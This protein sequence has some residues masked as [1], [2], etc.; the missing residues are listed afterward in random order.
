MSKSAI[1]F[2][3]WISI[4]DNSWP[5][6]VFRKHTQ[7]LNALMWANEPATKYV[8]KKLKE[9]GA[10]MDDK[11]SLHFNFAVQDGREV[12]DDLED[13]SNSFNLFQNWTNL[14][15]LMAITSNFETYIATIVSL[16]I[17]SDPGILYKSPKSIDGVSLLKKGAGKFPFEDDILVSF[18]KG[19]W[20]SRNSAFL[21]YFDHVPLSISENI[22]ELEKI[23]KLR[24]KVA[25]SFGRDIERSRN[26]EVKDILPME[27]LTTSK[28]IKIRKLIWQ[29]VTNIDEYLLTNHIGEYQAIKYYHSIAHEL[30]GTPGNKAMVFKK[31]IGAL[32][33]LS[34]K[35]FCQGLVKYY[36]EI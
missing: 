30:K 14:N 23:R 11:A 3:R 18:T 26:K 12:Y 9:D 36:D 31:K 22:S 2:N 35:I 28:F 32:G 1:E 16:A 17:E 8:Y 34:G 10:K 7:E 33:D 25:H 20:N 6:Q 4:R 19:D 15:G 24:N 21:K 27:R 13:W 5:F 29:C